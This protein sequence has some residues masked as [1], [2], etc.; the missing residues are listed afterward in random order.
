M[1]NQK[2]RCRSYNIRLCLYL[3]FKRI[4]DIICSILAAVILSPVFIIAAILV[5]AEDNGCIFYTHRR[6]GLGGRHI[7]IYKFRSM[8]EGADKLEDMLTPEQLE[9]YSKEFKLD[10]DP[11]VT[12]IGRFLRK[13][14]IDE[15]PQL[16]N[17]LRGEMSFVGPRPVLPQ[18][19]AMVYSEAEQ[20]K[21][22][23]VK[24]GLTGYWAAYGQKGSLYGNGDRQRMEL[25]Y[26]ENR[27]AFLD[28]KILFATVSAVIY[29]M[30]H[31]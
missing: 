5:K 30:K 22:L 6:V 20:Q 21:I 25:Y 9:E 15:L 23:S 31:K 1:E 27:S 2:A 10:D 24:P 28:I 4:F 16:I 3:C 12:R 13:S 19:L 29:R 8:E 7:G 17:I 11:R 26:V 18:E 14:S